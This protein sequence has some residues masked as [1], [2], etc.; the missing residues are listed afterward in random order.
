MGQLSTHKVRDLDRKTAVF[1]FWEDVKDEPGANACP[2]IPQEFQ[3]RIPRRDIMG[4][5]TLDVVDGTLRDIMIANAPL[6]G[7]CTR[8]NDAPCWYCYHCRTMLRERCY[9]RDGEIGGMCPCLIPPTLPESCWS[10]R[11]H[12]TYWHCEYCEN[13]ICLRCQSLGSGCFCTERLDRSSQFFVGI[14]S[15][16]RAHRSESVMLT[17]A[18]REAEAEEYREYQR[19]KRDFRQ[20]Y[21][22]DLEAM[23][24]PRHRRLHETNM[25][26]S[27]RLH[28]FSSERLARLVRLRRRQMDRLTI[29]LTVFDILIR[30]LDRIEHLRER[31]QRQP[32]NVNRRRLSLVHR[33]RKARDVLPSRTD[34]GNV[35]NCR[36]RTTRTQRSRSR[37][38]SPQS[39][40]Y[41]CRDGII[42]VF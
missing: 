18:E 27:L 16:Y 2:I 38:R 21:D 19:T 7:H 30:H 40:S 8:C 42:R 13:S 26:E 20:R 33:R 41:L 25:M 24:Y 3:P 12:R 17:D 28:H 10:S 29:V 22:A 32:N 11:W 31:P 15:A 1:Y 39:K 4:D 14:R 6:D 35:G 36:S 9:E 34:G 37:Y 5:P 23:R